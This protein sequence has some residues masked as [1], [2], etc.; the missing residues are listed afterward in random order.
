[1]PPHFLLS[2]LFGEAEKLPLKS[3]DWFRDLTLQ[4]FQGIAGAQ[5]HDNVVVTERINDGGNNRGVL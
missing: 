1:M 3:C 2:C 4:L 5:A